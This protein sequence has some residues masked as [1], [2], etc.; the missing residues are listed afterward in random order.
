MIRDK[1]YS[2]RVRLFESMLQEHFQAEYLCT[3]CNATSGILGTFYALGLSNSEIVTTPLTWAGAIT[4]LKLLGNEIVYA[5]IEEPTLTLNPDTLE[6]YIT[7]NTKAVFSAD[8]LGY[9]CKLDKIR[10]ICDKHGIYLIHDAASSFGSQYKNCFSGRFAHI[11]IFSFGRNKSFTTGEGGCLISH[12][13]ELFDIIGRTIL[14]PERQNIQ[15]GCENRFFI[16][17]SINSLAID[18]GI[19]TFHD[20]LDNISTHI[21]TLED[22]HTLFIRSNLDDNVQ[23]NYYK[24]IHKFKGN[25]NIKR[26]ILG[27]SYLPLNSKLGI[28]YESFMT[29]IILDKKYILSHLANLR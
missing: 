3:I 25:T 2:S 22:N 9:P 26:E 23:P 8:F 10:S 16:N 12:S 6:Q 7:P 1:V 4:P 5:E 19:S 29:Y 13:K 28:S 27:H 24:L 17:T 20:Q 18:Y 11:S 15:L 14:H 21:K